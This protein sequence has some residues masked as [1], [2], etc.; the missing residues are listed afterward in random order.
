MRWLLFIETGSVALSLPLRDGSA[1]ETGIF[2]NKSVVSATA[3]I[4]PRESLHQATVR[5]AGHG[6]ICSIENG[7]EEFARAEGFHDLILADVHALL[8][9]VTQ[10][11]A[12]KPPAR[13]ATTF[14]P[15]DAALPR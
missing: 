4:G 7:L 13:C 15:L 14:M 10:I 5:C 9:Q 1:I 3:L 12:C 8:M 6:F 2:G 11:A